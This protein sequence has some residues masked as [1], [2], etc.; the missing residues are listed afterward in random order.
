MNGGTGVIAYNDDSQ[1]NIDYAGNGGLEK[2][3]LV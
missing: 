3:I 2:L 1:A